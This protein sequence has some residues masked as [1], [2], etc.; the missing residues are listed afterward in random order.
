M[1]LIER[2]QHPGFITPAIREDTLD[3]LDQLILRQGPA[4]E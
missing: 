4:S 2:P 1:F 3:F